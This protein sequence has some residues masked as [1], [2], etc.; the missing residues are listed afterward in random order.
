M[1]LIDREIKRYREIGIGWTIVGTTI[2]LAFFNFWMPFCKLL[3]PT[4]M[5]IGI[6]F[7]LEPFVH[8]GIWVTAMV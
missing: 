4:Y 6:D 7:E 1:F 8:T 5:Q 2:A 3:W